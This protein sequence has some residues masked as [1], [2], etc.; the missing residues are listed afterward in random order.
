MWYCRWSSDNWKSDVYCY[1]SACGGFVLHVAAM[2]RDPPVQT[3]FDWTTATTVIETM[4]KQ[5]QELD[6][7]ELVPIGLPHDGK[8]FAFDTVAELY[9][10]LLELRDIGYHVPEFALKAIKEEIEDDEE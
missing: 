1:E 9:D 8:S 5:R 10:F 3:K 7:A 6:A 2:R 4:R